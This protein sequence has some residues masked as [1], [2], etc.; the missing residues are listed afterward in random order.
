MNQK[1]RHHYIPKAYL[2]AF[3]N[4]V[5]RVL[6]Y[7]KDGNGSPLE[8]VPDATQFRGYYYSQPTP[9]GGVDNNKLEDFFSEFESK[10]PPLVR[11]LEARENVNDSLQD[12]LSFMTLQRARVPACRDAVEATVAASVRGLAREMYRAGQLPAL[13]KGSENLIEEMEISIDPHRSIHAMK[14]IM[15][16]IG[17]LVDSVGWAIVYNKTAIPFLTSDN[18]VAWYDSALPFAEQNPYSIR[19]DGSIAV[20]FPISPKMLLLGATEY[21]DDFIRNGLAS[22]EVSDIEWIEVIN[23]Q[24]CR[25]GYEAVISPSRCQGELIGYYSD[26]SPVHEV[27]SVSNENQNLLLHRYVFGARTKKPKWKSS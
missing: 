27:E 1:K 2:N 13:P 12:L 24:T 25:F 14:A 9:E 21:R 3:C 7:R 4:E 16:G 5:G 23:A 20:Q 22:V 26:I 11:R 17:E 19:L 6:V 15:H 18:P 10:W 8:V